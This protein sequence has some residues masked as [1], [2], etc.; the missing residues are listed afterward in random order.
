MKPA[1]PR[2]VGVTVGTRSRT[3]RQYTGIDISVCEDY[4]P[5]VSKLQASIYLRGSIDV[6]FAGNDGGGDKHK[7]QD[8][9]QVISVICR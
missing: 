8:H 2:L 5:R 9:I 6:L 3:P 1:V 4:L 7:I